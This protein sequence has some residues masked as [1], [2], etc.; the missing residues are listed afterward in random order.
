M[1]QQHNARMYKAP[2]WPA[3]RSHSQPHSG[4]EQSEQPGLLCTR[5]V[6]RT[7]GYRSKSGFPQHV[8]R[9]PELRRCGRK[10]GRAWMWDLGKLRNGYERNGWEPR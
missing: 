2:P 1:A 7:L 8:Q 10:A 5:D 4:A 9:H 3:S 6:A